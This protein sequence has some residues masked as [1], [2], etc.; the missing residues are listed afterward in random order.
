MKFIQ[1]FTFAL[2]TLSIS[3]VACKKDPKV[4]YPATFIYDGIEADFELYT[5]A[6]QG[7]EWVRIANSPNYQPDLSIYDTY[8][9]FESI[10]LNSN[11]SLM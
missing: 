4:D 7:G 5:Y 10:T 1:F 6:K 9:S 11:S 8:G 3:M 2:L